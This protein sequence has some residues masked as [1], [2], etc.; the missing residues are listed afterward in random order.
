MPLRAFAP[1]Y[2][3]LLRDRAAIRLQVRREARAWLTRCAE[4]LARPI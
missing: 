3:R 1:F 2:V 4:R